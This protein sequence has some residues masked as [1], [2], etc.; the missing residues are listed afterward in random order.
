MNGSREHPLR[1]NIRYFVG[2][3]RSNNAR[4]AEALGMSAATFYAK[5]K[6]PTKFTLGDLDKMADLWVTTVDRLITD[7]QN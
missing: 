6:D 3:Y 7:F 1:S 2:L 5:L 4:T